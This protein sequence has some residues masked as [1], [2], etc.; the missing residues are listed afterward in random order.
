[1]NFIKDVNKA[2]RTTSSG[3]ESGENLSAELTANSGQSLGTGWSHYSFY[4]CAESETT[5]FDTTGTAITA[6]GRKLEFNISVAMS[7]SF[8]EMSE[9]KI[10]F[11]PMP[12][13]AKALIICLIS[14]WILLII[15][16]T[17][18]CI[19]TVFFKC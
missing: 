7:R 5:C 3:E 17:I 8:V 19:W 2:D 18:S 14:V 10:D 12:T 9:E 13:G 6:D 15:Y 11:G 16:F 4:Y 1:M